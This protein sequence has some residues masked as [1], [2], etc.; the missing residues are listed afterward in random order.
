MSRPLNVLVLGAA[1]RMGRM[2]TAAVRASEGLRAVGGV[3]LEGAVGEAG[4]PIFSNLA[5]AVRETAAQVAID[6]TVA[7]A[8]RV[9]LP[10]LVDLGVAPVIGTTGLSESELRQLDGQGK[11]HGVPL[12]MAPNFA[13][14]AVL[15]MR[16]AAE[17][18]KYFE[19]AEVIEYHHENKQDAPSGTALRTVEGMLTARGKAFRDTPVDET[20][21]LPGARGGTRGF[22][23]VHSVR[24][25]GVVADQ[26]VLL[27]GPGETL[28]LA[29][30][31]IDRGCFMPGVVL[32]AR[33]V[34]GLPPGLTVGLD[35]LLT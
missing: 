26:D 9:N 11:Q 22:V 25:P 23:H 6:F 32:A 20:E 35:T 1:G 15:L 5:A 24:M 13:I 30:R 29:H 21:L 34:L 3:D 16:F 31:S 2:V 12:F 19:Y 33:R 14:G 8:A 4:L 7:A 18:A 10:Q 17:A 28:R 27:G